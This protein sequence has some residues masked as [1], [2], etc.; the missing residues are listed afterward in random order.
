MNPAKRRGTSTRP[1]RGTRSLLSAACWGVTP[2]TRG[3]PDL[4][5]ERS[6][7]FEAGFEFAALEG[8]FSADASYYHQKTDNALIELPQDPTTGFLDAQIDN[9]G[10]FINEG[11]ELALNGTVIR[12]DRFTWD[13]GVIGSTLRS[14]IVDL[15][16]TPSIF[17]GGELTPGMFAREGHPLPAYFGQVLLNPNEIGAPVTEE[18]YIGPMYPT[19]TISGS[20]TLSIGPRLRATARVE[21]QGGHY[22]LSHTAWRNA[23]RGVWPPCFD[24]A[25][26]IDAGQLEQLTARERFECG[27]SF[28]ANWGAYIS[29]A[30]FV[31]LRSVA[32]Q[33]P[34]AGEL[35]GQ[36]VG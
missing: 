34:G 7:E 36:A 9:A 10:T 28:I 35:P 2:A 4:G 29:P 1:G 22:Q 18:R 32:G 19:R 3:N 23:Q 8:R 5:P 30:D 11:F 27:S 12:N 21:H 24:V 26:Q 31:K 15:G 17:L 25:Q 13:L 6:K 14:E 16:A 33:L 20:T